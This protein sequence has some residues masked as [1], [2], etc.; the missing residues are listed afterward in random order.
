MKIIK[1]SVK[2]RWVTPNILKTIEEAGRTCYKSENKIT[3]DSA[4][5]FVANLIKN[6]HESVLEHGVISIKIICD[7]GILAEITRH[8]IA[9]FSVESSRYVSYKNG[10]EVIQPPI[11]DPIALAKWE[12]SMVHA[13]NTYKDMIELGETP[14]I[15]RGVL[16]N[17]LKTEIVMTTNV[18]EFRHILKLRS[19]KGV[20]PQFI[21]ITKLILEKFNKVV[22]ELFG[23]IT[24]E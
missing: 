18:R 20:H 16:P 7:R 4:K 3:E 6:N 12:A 15:A 1:P 21:E 24:C 10:I 5:R 23:D 8:R 2:I 19:K 17:S 13:E 14:E 9:S 22:P 11:K